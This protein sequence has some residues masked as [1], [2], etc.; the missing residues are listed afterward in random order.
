MDVDQNKF[1]GPVIITEHG[2]PVGASSGLFNIVMG[3]KDIRC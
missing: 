3:M 2:K 1:G